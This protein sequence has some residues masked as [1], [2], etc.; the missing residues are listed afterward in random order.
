MTGAEFV[1]ASVALTVG[2][3]GWLVVSSWVAMRRAEEAN[4]RRARGQSQ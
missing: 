2:A 1:L 4:R 3:T